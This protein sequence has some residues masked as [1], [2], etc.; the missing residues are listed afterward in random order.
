MR[1]E[2][3]SLDFFIFAGGEWRSLYCKISTTDGWIGSKHQVAGIYDAEN[4]MIRVYCDG[5]MI[6][7]KATGTTAG[8]EPSSYPI[9]IGLCP[10]TLRSSQAE[11]YE[12]RIYSKALTASELASQ[13]TNSPA[14]APD[15]KYVKLWLDFDNL[16][17]GSLAGDINAD[18]N[19]NIAD[20]LLLQ[21]YL[22]NNTKFTSAQYIAADMDSDGKV[23]GFDMVLLRQT[24]LEKQL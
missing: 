16:A 23:N 19:V 2:N 17:E 13:N 3:G 1:T 11:F 18:G 8:V 4:N 10:E 7:E 12:V 22:L 14:Y 24:L 21:K 20:L 5:K 15:S 6:G 9:T